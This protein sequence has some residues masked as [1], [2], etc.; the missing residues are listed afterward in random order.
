MQQKFKYYVCINLPK[1]FT[2]AKLIHA[3]VCRLDNETN[4][5]IIIT[6][7]ITYKTWITADSLEQN[8]WQHEDDV[9]K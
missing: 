3:E 8:L 7:N 6:N 9:L 2:T 1:K 4:I 5:I